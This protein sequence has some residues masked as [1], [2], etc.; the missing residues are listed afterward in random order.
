MLKK[1]YFNISPKEYQVM[2]ALFEYRGVTIDQLLRILGYQ[3]SGLTNMYKPIQSLFT[4]GYISAYAISPK[5]SKKIYF[6]SQKGYS[7]MLEHLCIPEGY[8]GVG[9]N[10]DYGD[11]PYE[12][13][14]PPNNL[15]IHHLL[16][17]DFLI[18]AAEFKNEF[19]INA[20]L[21]HTFVYRDNRYATRKY[22][23]EIEDSKNTDPKTYRFR[24]DAEVLINSNTCFIEIDTGTERGTNLNK[25][26]EGYKKYFDYLK[27]TK[28]PLPS[29][30]IFISE[31]L[32]SD[33]Q[34]NRRWQGIASSFLES[35]E[36]YATEVNLMYETIDNVKTLLIR[37]YKSEENQRK[38]NELIGNYF[39]RI[40]NVKKFEGELNKLPVTTN[41]NKDKLYVYCNVDGYET[42]GWALAWNFTKELAKLDKTKDVTPV[43]YYKDSEPVPLNFYK[44]KDN[45]G[46]F[47]KR[48]HFKTKGQTGIWLD[49]NF[50]PTKE[51]SSDNS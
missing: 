23:Q 45:E 3:T 43:L 49:R 18:T 5:I 7:L 46:Y 1:K 17:V 36:E 47:E 4:L 32:E 22:K 15:K 42:K 26:F 11:F 10:K 30:I 40:V 9:F 34:K 6:L 31:E 14:K 44:K 16:L 13:Y 21:E 25:K 27:E 48:L 28:Q 50:E 38:A 41:S 51:P 33:V 35:L 37:E 2:L 20:T 8:I 12:L 39:S 24:P 29:R 19:G